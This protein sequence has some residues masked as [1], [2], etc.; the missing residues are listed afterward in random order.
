MDRNDSLK[1]KITTGAVAAAVIGLTVQAHGHRNDMT[2]ATA[3][4]TL[5]YGQVNSDW[6]N[7]TGKLI[8]AEPELAA[9]L[10]HIAVS[11]AVDDVR[12]GQVLDALAQAGCEPAQKAMRETLTTL[13]REPV[14]PMLLARLGQLTAPSAETLSYVSVQRMRAFNDGNSELAY[15]AQQT[16]DE[17]YGHRLAKL[18]KSARKARVAPSR[19]RRE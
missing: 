19:Q 7:R 16:L 17:V 2:A 5:V 8:A 10:E 18:Y 4:H 6:V 14:Y 1:L 13:N 3:E 11:N 12:R 15:S 9:R